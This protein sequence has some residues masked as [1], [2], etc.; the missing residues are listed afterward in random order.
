MDLPGTVQT[1]AR[2]LDIELDEALLEIVVRQSSFD[3]ML[4]HKDKFDDFLMREYFVRRGMH[5]PGGDAAKVR[6]GRVGD[7]RQE[8]PTE[9]S[10]EMDAIWRDE[11]EAKLGLASYQALRETLVEESC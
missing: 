6:G 5:P 2:F 4:A 1:I 11:I 10:A 3:F 9:I 8:L 7:H